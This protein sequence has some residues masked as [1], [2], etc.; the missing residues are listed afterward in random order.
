M[1][2][3]ERF[4]RST[5]QWQPWYEEMAIDQDG[6][7][8]L[9]LAALFG[10]APVARAILETD[11]VILEDPAPNQYQRTALHL[12]AQL[13]HIETVQT[14]LDF[15]ADFTVKDCEKEAL[16]DSPFLLAAFSGY[17][18]VVATFIDR[19]PSIVTTATDKL[20][21]FAINKAASEG[22]LDTVE[23]LLAK[24]A[25]VDQ[26]GYRGRT[27]VMLA[28]QHGHFDVVKTLIEQYRAD[29]FFKD[30]SPFGDM[31]IHLAA[32][33]GHCEIV[34]YFLKLRKDLRV[35]KNECGHTVLQ[36]ASAQR[37]P[38]VVRLLHQQGA[39]V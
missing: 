32:F 39:K 26:R 4:I 16:G 33:N 21:N 5:L 13:G 34:E 19:N 1:V 3:D 30:F 8:A 7:S 24:G 31:A 2:G 25:L 14:L 28:S 10:H 20:G 37:Q 35:A 27:P 15:G 22:H 38:G 36:L 11:T 6:H 12:A 17:T 18:N 29:I 23:F 9:H